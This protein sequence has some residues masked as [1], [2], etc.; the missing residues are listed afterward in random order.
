LRARVYAHLKFEKPIP[1]EY[2]EW[3]MCELWHCPP[4][5]L[6]GVPVVTMYRHLSCIAGERQ[7]QEE[8]K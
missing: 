1:A 5:A 2:L 3:K 4:T 8:E 6:K 7:Y